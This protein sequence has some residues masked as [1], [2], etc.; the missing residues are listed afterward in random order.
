MIL[1]HFNFSQC[2]DEDIN[3]I[4]FTMITQGKKIV[5]YVTPDSDLDLAPDPDQF[6]ALPPVRSILVCPSG[7]LTKLS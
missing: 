6:G 2:K 7:D 5:G 3:F 4:C 1:V